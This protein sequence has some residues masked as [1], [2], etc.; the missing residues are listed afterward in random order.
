MDRFIQPRPDS[1][2]ISTTSV[3]PSTQQDT[4]PP[5]T[6]QETSLGGGRKPHTVMTKKRFAGM[7]TIL[8]TTLHDMPDIDQTVASVMQQIKDL[9]HFDPTASTYTPEVGKKISA[10]RRRKADAALAAATVSNVQPV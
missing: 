3:A 10:Y 5:P 7:E 9:L 1:L 2:A 8:Q 6:Q 4:P